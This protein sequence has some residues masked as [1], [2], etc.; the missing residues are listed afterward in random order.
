MG[1]WRRGALGK[2]TSVRGCVER[3][4]SD[5]FEP[6]YFE[7]KGCIRM[8]DTSTHS[9]GLD[10]LMTDL[11]V[12][13]ED[14]YRERLARLV[15]YGSRARGDTHAESDVDV[16]V[17]LEGTVNPGREIRRMRDVRT[18]LGLRYEQAL[19]LLPVSGT[20]YES[21]SSAWLTN[22]RREGKAV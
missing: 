11:R 2:E 7:E 16:L 4:G 19:S 18:R 6:P 1:A 10:S 21:Q 5:L 17:V 3:E 14:L 8:A 22:A 13:L 9:S 15:L 12:A 20:E